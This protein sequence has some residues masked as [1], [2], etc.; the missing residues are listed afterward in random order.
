M[1]GSR[2]ISWCSET[3]TRLARASD[4]ACTVRYREIRLLSFR[5]SVF[6]FFSRS[7]WLNC[8]SCVFPDPVLRLKP[9]NPRCVSFRLVFPDHL[10]SLPRHQRYHCPASSLPFISVL[11]SISVIIL[12]FIPS[13]HPRTRSL[14]PPFSIVCFSLPPSWILG[15]HRKE[16][17]SLPRTVQINCL[18]N[19]IP[20][21]LRG[22][23]YEA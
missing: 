7:A 4:R 12:V 6:S 23:L 8:F 22:T 10:F 14:S 20:L 5:L 1:T 18:R 9:V 11:L 16:R 21:G 15:L 3:D 2:C 13:D 19:L 17:E